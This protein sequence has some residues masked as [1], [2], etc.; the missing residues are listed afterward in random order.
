[1]VSMAESR[2][3]ISSAFDSGN[4]EALGTEG[5]KVRL[6]IRPDPYTELEQKHHLQWF[7][8]RSMVSMEDPLGPDLCSDI[9]NYEIENAG[10]CSFPAAWKGSS[11]CYSYDRQSWNR[12]AAEY[13]ES[14][15]KLSWSFKHAAPQGALVYFSY[16]D[17]YSYERHASFVSQCIAARGATVRSLGQ[18]LD[19]RDLECISV[20]E[21]PLQLWVIHRQH[22]GESQA[23]FF[24]EGLLKRLLGLE[25]EGRRDGLTAQLLKQ[26]T[27]HAVP[28][29]NPD[30]SIRGHLRTNAAGANLNREWQT[31]GEYSAPTLER[32]PEVHHV[33]RAMDASGVDGFVDVHGDEELPFAFVAG[34]EGCRNWGARLESLQG[35][36]LAAYSRANSDMQQAV[37]YEP[38]PPGEANLA[39]CSNQIAVRFDALAVTLEMPFKDSASHPSDEA[40][41]DGNRAAM[42]GASLVDALAYVAP[43]LRTEAG[44]LPHFPPADAY[45]RASPE[46][47]L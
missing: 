11:I 36:F 20:G 43:Q 14:T 3:S 31:T 5:N 37:G 24:A 41:F 9:V 34:A 6:K 10:E 7:S 4:I 39:V 23:S 44:T 1:M 40:G 19:G 35:A 22:P 45:V 33:L 26:C 46:Y 29:M 21:G 32:S 12:C 15:G 38:E 18:T 27:V 42:L 28:N 47:I 2:I 13:D 25:T 8:F 16:F 30:G 17:V